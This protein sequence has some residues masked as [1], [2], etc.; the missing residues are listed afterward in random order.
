[1]RLPVFVAGTDENIMQ[2]IADG[3]IKYPAYIWERRSGEW[4]FLDNNGLVLKNASHT[5]VTSLTGTLEN[6]VIISELAEDG[7]YAI[8]GIYRLASVPGATLY[9]TNTY[10][11]V[12]IRTEGNAKKIKR[13]SE[14]SIE[15][16]T[17]EDGTLTIDKY[18]TESY[19]VS[20]GYV[21]QDTMDEKLTEIEA[22]LRD[23]VDGQIGGRVGEI[24]EEVLDKE[25]TLATSDQIREL[26]NDDENGGN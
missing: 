6:P 24:V 12:S 3:K 1:M 26:F 18:V 7:L 23:Y 21:S 2:A 4:W 19:L 16:Y 20:K 22:D 9:S 14:G 15:D 17:I 11:L 8:K 10:V 25:L 13:I 5:P